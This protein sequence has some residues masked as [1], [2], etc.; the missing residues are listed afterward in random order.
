MEE[1]GNG[2]LGAP[3]VSSP[4]RSRLSG[5]PGNDDRFP[6][7]LLAPPLVIV[8][9]VLLVVATASE[10][11]LVDQGVFQGAA[12]PGRTL[13]PVNQ[14]EY[15]AVTLS[16]PDLPCPLLVYPLT[17]LDLTQYQEEG[18]LPPRSLNC[19]NANL[20][21]ERISHFLL[22]N[23]DP[24]EPMNYTVAA[25]FYRLSQP[26]AWL[27]VP[28]GALLLVGTAMVI[29]WLLQRGLGGLSRSLDSKRKE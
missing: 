24:T 21:A 12:P 8:G 4:R 9:V 18:I 13:L 6:R 7:V 11:H 3:A 29:V 23:V 19:Q 15:G 26:H 22:R 1:A 16:A 10:A 14:T 25:Q 20:T 17:P 2:S 27:V 28:G 5:E